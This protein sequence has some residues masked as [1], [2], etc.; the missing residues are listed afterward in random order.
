[1]NG[2]DLCRNNKYP[3]NNLYR[4]NHR[5][6]RQRYLLELRYVLGNFS[7]VKCHVQERDSN[8]SLLEKRDG[9]LYRE[10][11]GECNEF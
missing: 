1:M 2:L 10:V 8:T 3:S 9:H 7:L 5:I 4:R 6:A 11:D